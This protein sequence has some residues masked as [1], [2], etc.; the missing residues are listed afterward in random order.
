MPRSDWQRPPLKPLV[1]GERRIMLKVAYNGTHY[2]GWQKQTNAHSVVGELEQALVKMLEESVVIIGSGRTDSGVHAIGQVCHFDILNKKI[3]GTSFAPAL[4]RLLPLDIRILESCEVDGTF[5]SRFSTM[6]RMYRYYIKEEKTVTPFDDHQVG[7]IRKFPEISLLQE[8]AEVIQ[9]T[10][11][12][13][14]FTASGDI[15]PSKCRDIYESF[16]SYETD[17]WGSKVLVYTICGNAFLYKMVRSLVGSMIEFSEKQRPVS[18]FI[19]A[20]ASKDRHLAG[21]T[22]SPW[23]LYLVRISYDKQEYAWFEEKSNE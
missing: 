22:A 12:F 2:S 23:G 3:R 9:G 13:T 6:A 11:D 4:N 18:D 7:K 1:E 10:H 19:Q 21:R 8:Y 14:T 17:R 16:W 5:H 15:C 20:L